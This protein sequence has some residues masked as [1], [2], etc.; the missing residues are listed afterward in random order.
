MPVLTLSLTLTATVR[1][2][3]SVSVA[4]SDS[5]PL[6]DILS[7]CIGFASCSVNV[8]TSMSMLAVAIASWNLSDSAWASRVAPLLALLPA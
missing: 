2:T 5:L 7:P 8:P 3:V 6:P 1:L 4:Q